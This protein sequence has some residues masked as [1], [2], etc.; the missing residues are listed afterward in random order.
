[1][2]H[3]NASAAAVAAVATLTLAACGADTGSGAEGETAPSTTGTS[4]D[5]GPGASPDTAASR[6]ADPTPADEIP[7]AEVVEGSF[8]VLPSAPETAPQS[9]RGTVWLARHDDG[10]TVT[11]DVTGLEPDTKYTSH[12]H[13]ESCEPDD[14]GPHFRFDPDGPAQ[15]PNE[16][17]LMFTTD[18]EGSAS[19]TVTNPNPDSD[20]A[21]AILL[22]LDDDAG[23]K[24]ACADL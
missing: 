19:T 14:G 1:M 7:D 12:L 8:A 16:V 17:H 5:N 13:A 11:V 2:R 6:A 3:L 21:N 20:G 23:T 9:V 10:T 18:S 4:A 24:F 15:P 22:H